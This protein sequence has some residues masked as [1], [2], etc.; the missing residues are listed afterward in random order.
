M[1][2]KPT[3]KA[4]FLFF[5]K[6]LLV[7]VFAISFRQS[8]LYSFNQ[9]TYFVHG[10]ANADV[11]FLKLDWLA[12]TTDPFPVFSAL[13]T[14]TIRGLGAHAFYF[15]YMAILAIYAYSILGIACIVFDIDSSSEKYLSYFALITML[16]SGLL[17]S[18][19]SKL[20]GSQLIAPI[21]DPNGILIRG[22][23]E[24]TTLSPIFQPSVF[25]VFLVLSIYSFLREKPFVAGFWLAIAAT[26]HASYL[27]CAAVL[28]CIYM[29][30][31]VVQEQDY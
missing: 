17:F 1:S 22:V 31:I 20:P 26:F 2:I 16:Y 6:L 21:F 19:L 27:L 7:L 4:R 29:A 5:A 23:A 24:Q 25:G 8:P 10:L 12:Q 13:V 3:T 30:V 14:I 28:T 11:G 18:L 15:F 9:N